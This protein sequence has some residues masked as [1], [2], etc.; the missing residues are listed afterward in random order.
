MLVSSPGQ[1]LLER[2]CLRF[3][4]GPTSYYHKDLELS[5]LIY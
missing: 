3:H 4:Q 1:Y 5:M 2:L